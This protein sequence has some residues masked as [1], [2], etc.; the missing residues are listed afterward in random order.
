MVSEPLFALIGSAGALAAVKILELIDQSSSKEQLPQEEGLSKLKLTNVE[1]EAQPLNAIF[2]EKN[3]TSE[4]FTSNQTKSTTMMMTSIAHSPILEVNLASAAATATATAAA[5]A[6]VVTARVGHRTQLDVNVSSLSLI[7]KKQPPVVAGAREMA[8]ILPPAARLINA[9]PLAG[10]LAAATA[11][12]PPSQAMKAS[13]DAKVQDAR[14]AAA[15]A[16]ADA[17]FRAL[18]SRTMDAI[19]DNTAARVSS[20]SHS[21]SSIGHGD[22]FADEEACTEGWWTASDTE[23]ANF[24]AAALNASPL[25]TRRRRNRHWFASILLLLFWPMTFSVNLLLVVVRFIAGVMSR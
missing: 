25:S 19:S 15:A 10:A 2:F 17:K 11:G 8:K 23:V 4:K 21:S 16:A 18:K 13:R 7:K 22:T 6:A 3:K 20:S 9:S 1:P 12:R 14:A 5:K 24:E